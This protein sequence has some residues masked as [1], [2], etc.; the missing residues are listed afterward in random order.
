MIHCF[1]CLTP[2]AASLGVLHL[3]HPID[4]CRFLPQHFAAKLL[5]YDWY[6]CFLQCRQSL[7]L[8]PF[9]H[10]H[11]LSPRLAEAFQVPRIPC[12]NCGSLDYNTACSL[13]SANVTNNSS[14]PACYCLGASLLTVC[15]FSSSKSSVVASRSVTTAS[16]FVV[17]F[18]S[19]VNYER[20]NGM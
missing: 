9:L 6:F 18:S 10:L 16:H 20:I 14:T 19:A 15:F 17:P 1:L 4:H 7:I 3:H 2:W 13:P 8:L 12:W 11:C 5:D